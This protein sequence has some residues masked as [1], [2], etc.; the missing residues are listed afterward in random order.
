MPQDFNQTVEGA[1]RQQSRTMRGGSTIKNWSFIKQKKRTAAPSTQRTEILN[2]PI[3]LDEPI[4]PLEISPKPRI[5]NPVDIITK[6]NSLKS[7]KSSAFRESMKVTVDLKSQIDIPQKQTLDDL[8]ETNQQ[9]Q[10]LNED[11]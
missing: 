11:Q 1:E 4:S 3:N 5:E 6:V 8:L 9:M 7:M 10:T 2:S